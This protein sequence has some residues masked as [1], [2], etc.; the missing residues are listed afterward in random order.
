VMPF[1]GEGKIHVQAVIFTDAKGKRPAALP[2]AIAT[3]PKE[4]EGLPVALAIKYVLP[5]P[6]GVIV[7]KPG[8]ERVRA[9][10]CPPGNIETTHLRWRFCLNFN[11]PEAIPP[12]MIP[13]IA[14]IA[15]EEAFKILERHRAELEALPGVV[16][17]GMGGSGISIEAKDLSVLPKEVEGLPIEASPYVEQ[18]IVDNSHNPD[19]LPVRGGLR[20]F[21]LGGLS[22]PETTA[23]GVAYAGGG[24]WLIFP[25]HSLPSPECTTA[26]PALQPQAWPNV[27]IDIR[28]ALLCS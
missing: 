16:S 6:P 10:T 25:S 3:F 9:D 18:I 17:V 1:P 12:I 28:L 20:M 27:A 21:T 26:P 15:Y 8:G 11:Q 13:P 24:M 23:T 7:V 22:S 4:I 5:P 14:G 2:P 19:G